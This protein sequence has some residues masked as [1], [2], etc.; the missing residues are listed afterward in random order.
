MPEICRVMRIIQVE[1][2]AG[3]KL[4]LTFGNKETKIVDLAE[5]IKNAKGIFLPLKDLEFFKKVAVDDC[6][7]SIFWP[8]GA[9]ICPDVLYKMGHPIP[10]KEAL[11][12]KPM[13]AARRAKKTPRHRSVP[14]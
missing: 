10:N 12:K 1:Y 4:K 8:N 13:A 9:D 5:K 3:Y 11:R 6:Q 14:K 7:L 2:M